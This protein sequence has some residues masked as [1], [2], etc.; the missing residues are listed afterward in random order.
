M[1]PETVPSAEHDHHFEDSVKDLSNDQLNSGAVEVPSSEKR[2]KFPEMSPQRHPQA[3][4]KQQKAKRPAVG[5]RER[6]TLS[7]R[8]SLADAGTSFESGV[9]RSKRMKTRPL[10]YWKGERLLYGRVNESLKLVGLKYISPGK[11]SFKVKSYIPDDYKNLVDLA[12]RY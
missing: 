9:R 1:P 5:R 10:E 4:D 2:S 8:P 12:A 3:K 7:S 6:K 11:G